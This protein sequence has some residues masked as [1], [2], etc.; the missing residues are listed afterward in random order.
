MWQFDRYVGPE[1]DVADIR[2]ICAI[3]NSLPGVTSLIAFPLWDAGGGKWFSYGLAWTADP[4]RVFERQDFGYLHSFVNSILVESSRI[5][6]L[7][8]NQAKNT[9][10]S[11]ISHEL[12]SPLH[13][14]MATMEILRGLTSDLAYEEEFATLEACGAT[15]LDTID[16]S[17]RSQRLTTPTQQALLVP[18]KLSI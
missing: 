18:A 2:E 3:P 4:T 14:I 6:S 1:M 12:R 13:G 16:M 15:L 11:S 10:V 5:E 8:A 17:S 9:F 7:A